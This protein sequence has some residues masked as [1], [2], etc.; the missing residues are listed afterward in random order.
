MQKI[1]QKIQKKI[2]YHMQAYALLKDEILNHRI[3][4]KDLINE[5][6]LS[7]E[8]QI[9]RSPIREAL[10][11]LECDKLLVSTPNGLIVNPLP[12]NEIKEIYDC[13][14]MLESFAAYLT[15]KIITD[16]QLDYLANCIAASKEA[17]AKGDI[18]TI[19]ENNTRFHE[20]IVE[21]CQNK[22]L[23]NLYNIN[24]NLS[25]LSRSNELHHRSDASYSE[26][27]LKILEVLRCHNG[28]LAESCMRNHINND[29]NY[30]L[31]HFNGAEND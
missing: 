17:H 10:R 4:G 9:S 21:F 28:P 31:T 12:P 20:G 19:L 23:L 24:R 7:H 18:P 16:D 26:D 8:L 11:M 29:R 22:Y 2:P 6:A 13:R 3:S 27:H 15:A 25:T 30:Y 5:S 14:I 1:Q